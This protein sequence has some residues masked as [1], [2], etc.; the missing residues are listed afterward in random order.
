MS[1]S[2]RCQ[3]AAALSDTL[4]LS[5]VV[6]DLWNPITNPKGFVNLGTAENTLMQDILP[7]HIHENIQLP[8]SAFTYGDGTVGTKR[9]RQAIAQFLTKRL[10][11]V[12]PLELRHISVTN[13]CNSAIEHLS[14]QRKATLGGLLMTQA[15]CNI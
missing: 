7:R 4:T 5:K 13:G 15:Q 14:W 6:C 2:T 10:K 9:L 12:K 1:A 8:R 11:P 3:E